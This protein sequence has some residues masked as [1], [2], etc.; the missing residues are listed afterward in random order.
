ME[1]RIHRFQDLAGNP[2]FSVMNWVLDELRIPKD[3]RN[4]AFYEAYVFYGL[5]RDV[6]HKIEK[7][8]R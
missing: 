3:K 5:P 2:W 8:F 6:E 1:A 7:S 4:P